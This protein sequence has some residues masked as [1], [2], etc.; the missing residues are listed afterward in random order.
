MRAPRGPTR[1]A[2]SGI[3]AQLARPPAAPRPAAGHCA[4]DANALGADRARRGRR[5]ADNLD[6]LDQLVADRLATARV[7]QQL[8]EPLSATVI[9]PQR[10]VTPGILVLDAQLA[11]WRRARPPASRAR[12]S[13]AVRGLRPA[14]E[15]AARDRGDERQPAQGRRRALAGGPAAPLLPAQALAPRARGPC[16]RARADAGRFLGRVAELDA[17]VEGPG[18]VPAARSAS[19]T[20]SAGRAA[21]AE[22][23]TLSRGLTEAVDRSWPPP[24]PTSRPPASRP[25]APTSQHRRARCRRARSLLSSA[26]IVWLYVDRNLVGRLQALSRSMLGSPAAILR[27]PLPAGGRRDR[28]DGRGAP[29]LPR[30]RG[31]GRGGA[32]ARAPGRARHDR[33][34]RPDPRPRAAGAHPQP[35]LR[36]PRGPRRRPAGAAALP[37]GHGRGPRGADLRRG[38]RRLGGYVASRLAELEGGEV[39]PREWR[40]GTGGC[41]STSACR[42]PTAGG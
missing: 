13:R 31:R 26:L 37:R 21:L 25:G 14:A 41:S 8:L 22:N 29:R 36:R 16:A 3:R 23:A 5:S 17:L 6:A 30:H 28:P 35:G 19:S 10:L 11:A 9:E 27:T 38:R 40:C 18:S 2:P 4:P 34:R 15:G 12:S 7:K 32:A 1:V 20:R 42:C 39:A 33:L 24:R